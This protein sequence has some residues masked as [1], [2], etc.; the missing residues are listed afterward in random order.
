[1]FDDMYT[2]TKYTVNTTILKT[3]NEKMAWPPELKKTWLESNDITGG[4]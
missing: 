1:M 4:L 3:F 2:P